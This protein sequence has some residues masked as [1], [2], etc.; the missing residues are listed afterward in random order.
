MTCLAVNL[1][2]LDARHFGRCWGVLLPTTREFA[3]EGSSDSKE[4][5]GSSVD[6][7]GGAFLVFSN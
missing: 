3:F 5:S 7:F 4:L 2:L 1:E 6:G